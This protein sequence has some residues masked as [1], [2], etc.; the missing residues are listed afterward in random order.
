LRIAIIG[1]LFA[2]PSPVP[3][4]RDRETGNRFQRSSKSQTSTLSVEALS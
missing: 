4:W 2:V 3:A 1:E